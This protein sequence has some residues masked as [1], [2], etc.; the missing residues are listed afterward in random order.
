MGLE[1]KEIYTGNGSTTV[2]DFD[3]RIDDPENQLL[4]YV[5]DTL[6]TYS[7][8]YTVEYEITGGSITFGSAPANNSVVILL[9]T[10]TMALTAMFQS[11]P[12]IEG[13]AL[14]RELDRLYR[15]VRMVNEVTKRAFRFAEPFKNAT[16]STVLPT[17]LIDAANAFLVVNADGNGVTKLDYDTLVSDILD[18][19]ASDGGLLLGDNNLSDL[20]DLVEALQN[21]ELDNVDNTADADKPV[22]TAQ[23]AAIDAVQDD[24]DAN[25]LVT[26]GHIADTDNPHSVTKAQVGLGSVDNTADADK[27][28]SSA[29]QIALDAKANA[30][31]VL[32]DP[33]VTEITN[34]MGATNITGASFTPGKF[35]VVRC[36][37]TRNSDAVLGSFELH[38]HY[39]SSTWRIVQTA[40]H[41]YTGKA[42]T[43]GLTFSMST[44]QLQVADSD[45]SGAGSLITQVLGEYD[46]A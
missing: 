25:E 34:S 33:V 15:T 20:T 6:Q 21:I 36:F 14:D 5:N 41:W 26:D 11:S 27:P 4:V 37:V 19:V 38:L 24:V 40:Y 30:S 32:P 31:A 3:F 42:P 1:V 28:I 39:D 9:Y 7:S 45:A 35:V 44:N 8:D 17:S 13:F 2:F 46:V 22:S 18:A 43:H 16:F 29:T 23:Q 12:R 10:N